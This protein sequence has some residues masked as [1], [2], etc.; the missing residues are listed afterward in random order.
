LLTVDSNVGDLRQSVEKMKGTTGSAEPG[1]KM[2]PYTEFTQSPHD[3]ALNWD[4]L[5]W[6]KE[7]AGDVPIYLKGVSSIDVSSFPRKLDPS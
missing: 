6:L 3:P 7:L 5:K 4:D 2:G 1:K